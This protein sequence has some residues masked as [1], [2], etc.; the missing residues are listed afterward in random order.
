MFPYIVLLLFLGLIMLLVYISVRGVNFKKNDDDN[1][2]PKNSSD[3]DDE[4]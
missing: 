3:F 2:T 1:E 4:N